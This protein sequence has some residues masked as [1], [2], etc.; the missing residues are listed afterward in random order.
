MFRVE[1]QPVAQTPTVPY[2]CD[3]CGSFETETVKCRVGATEK[4]TLL[5]IPLFMVIGAVL[6]FLTF[7]FGMALLDACHLETEVGLIGC[8]ALFML[9]LPIGGAVLGHLLGRV[10]IRRR[11]RKKNLSQTTCRC[12]MCKKIFIPKIKLG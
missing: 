3:Q 4:L 7:I 9:I 2:Y 10:F 6:G 8:C 11:R 1:I 12:K 5:L